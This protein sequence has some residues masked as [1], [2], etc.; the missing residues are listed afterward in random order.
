MPQWCAPILLALAQRAQPCTVFF[1]DDD[2]GWEDDKLFALLDCF[3]R[4]AVPIDLALIPAAL[5]PSLSRAL[6]QRIAA[7]GR[8]QVGLHQHGFAHLNHETSGRKCE[9]GP[10]RSAAEQKAAI[11]A[12]HAI[13]AA[14]F[15]SLADRIF[16]PPWNRCTA[17]TAKVLIELGFDAL[18]R[19]WSATPFD[20]PDLIELPVSVD[21]CKMRAPGSS[22]D[23]LAQRI[24]ACLAS[25]EH[26]GIMLHHAVMDVSDLSLLDSLLPILRQHPNARCVPMA[27]LLAPA[28][29]TL[30]RVRGADGYNACAQ[31]A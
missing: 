11:E 1:R 21:W 17:D 29:R 25:S 7:H 22:P 18:S 10:S 14:A 8:G 15:G 12:G 4:H 27:E 24:A 23:A 20:L 9:F 6:L 16:T 19:D 2:A 13:I 31:G 30:G 5:T 26:C 3:A 28:H